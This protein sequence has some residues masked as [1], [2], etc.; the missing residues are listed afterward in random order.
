MARTRKDHH[1]LTEEV[2]NLRTK[3]ISSDNW[4]IVEAEMKEFCN[5]TRRTWSNAMLYLLE[6]ALKRAKKNGEY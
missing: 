1:T 2:N 5:I 4:R 3:A 6:N